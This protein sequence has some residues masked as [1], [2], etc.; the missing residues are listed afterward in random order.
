MASN[1]YLEKMLLQFK[2]VLLRDCVRVREKGR[3]VHRRVCIW[4]EGGG[5]GGAKVELC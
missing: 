5:G 2:C 1:F 4:R 3:G